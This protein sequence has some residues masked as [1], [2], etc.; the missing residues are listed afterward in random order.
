MGYWARPARPVQ[1][2]R[3]LDAGRIAAAAVAL[4]DRAGEQAL[5]V[6]A[7][8]AE[9]G[10]AQSSLYAHV[11][12]IEDVLDLALDRVL[13]RDPR[14]MRPA[15]AET[16]SDL[17]TAWYEHMVAH[18]WVPRQVARAEPTGPGYSAL[19]ERFRALVRPWCP[20]AD[21]LT[22]TFALSDFALGSAITAAAAGGTGSTAGGDARPTDPLDVFRRGLRAMLDGFAVQR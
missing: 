20:P 2:R 3:A 10:V 4:L 17:L 22:V 11:D 16:L 19:A 12:G 18:P 8:A 9:L 15:P 5:T 1:R 6:R 13:E 7:V 14:L 21:V